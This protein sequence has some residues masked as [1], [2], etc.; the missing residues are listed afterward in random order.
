M[1]ILN[2]TTVR[3]LQDFSELPEVHGKNPVQLQAYIN[4]AEAIL[5]R[6]G[7]YD[8]S[9]TGCVANLELAVNML[10]ENLIILRTPDYMRSQLAGFRSETIGS[11]S[12]TRSEN[13]SGSIF[14]GITEEIYSLLR[15]CRV[16]SSDFRSMRT[17]VF[18][19][20]T[21]KTAIGADERYY[22]P[23]DERIVEGTVIID[24][25]DPRQR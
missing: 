13:M 9:L 25:A 14:M 10:A 22:V 18:M 3:K 19:P 8:L 6:I 23:E 2:A 21:F 11:Y 5:S 17:N 20:R 12:Y 16:G 7:D 15:S 4:R 24:P 1:G